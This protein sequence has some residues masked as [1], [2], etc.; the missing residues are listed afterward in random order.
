MSATTDPAALAL[1]DQAIAA[2]TELVGIM[3]LLLHMGIPPQDV[4]TVSVTILKTQDGDALLWATAT[5]LLHLAQQERG[6]P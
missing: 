5:A 2:T 4:W 3:R 1:Y 6:Q